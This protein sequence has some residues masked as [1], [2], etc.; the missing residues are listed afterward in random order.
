MFVHLDLSVEEARLRRIEQASLSRRV[1]WGQRIS[2]CISNGGGFLI[3]VLENMRYHRRVF[4]SVNNLNLSATMFTGFDVDIE[5]PFEALHPRHGP[6][7]WVLVQP[8]CTARFNLYCFLTTF[9]GSDLSTVFDVGCKQ[10]ME[11]CEIDARLGL[12][13]CELGDKV[14]G[15]E[16]GVCGAVTI[17]GF[18]F[19]ANLFVRG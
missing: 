2:L 16:D 3:Q 4:D 8:I 1:L 12:Q 5:H 13:G 14:Q 10:T 11:P 19:I 6:M 15:L 18:K 7:P 9:C 17:R